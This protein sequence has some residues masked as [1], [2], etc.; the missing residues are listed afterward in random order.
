MLAPSRVG[1]VGLNDRARRLLVPGIIAAPRGRLAAL[2][3]RDLAKAQDWAS[4]LGPDADAFD[5]VAAMGASGVVDV[6]FVNTPVTAHA[7]ACLAAIDAGCAVICEKPLAVDTAQAIIL[8]GA[9]ARGGVRTVVNYTYR[10]VLG[11]RLV[12][13]ILNTKTIGRPRHAEVALLQGHGFLPSFPAGSAR[14]DSGVHLLD[15]L[16]G[17]CGLAGLGRIVEVSA[18]PMLEGPTSLSGQFDPTGPSSPTGDLTRECAESSLDFGWGFTGRTQSGAVVTGAF[19]RRSLGWRNGFRW[20]LYGDEA[21]I[22]AELDS[23]RTEVRLAQRGDG[24]PQGAWRA[25]APP[26]DLAAD[27]ERFPAYH[28]DRLI[29]AARGE[30]AFPDFAAA[31]ATHRFADA[32]VASALSGR[33]TKVVS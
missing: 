1:L 14:L 8:A 23:D 15:T 4:G 16:T 22:L 24:R 7:A 20:S 9:A 32:L 30:E 12:E 19:S 11:Y 31:V 5:S 28:M 26:A 2:C 3:S 18:A 10:S 17:L 29:G 27:E 25:V 13:R 33:W 6:V 21:A